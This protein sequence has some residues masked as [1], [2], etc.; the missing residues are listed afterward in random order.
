MSGAGMPLTTAISDRAEMY[1]NPR[2]CI[3]KRDMQEF[4]FIVDKAGL[5]TSY[6][7]ER[8]RDRRTRLLAQNPERN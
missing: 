5:G 6:G 4:Q 3:V 1:V 2:R 8:Q 7:L